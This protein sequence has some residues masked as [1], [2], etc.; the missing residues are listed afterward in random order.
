M[1][2]AELK[3][4]EG[5]QQVVLPNGTRVTPAPFMRIDGLDDEGIER[6]L[7]PG[8]KILAALRTG[9]LYKKEKLREPVLRSCVSFIVPAD[10]H[11]DIILELSLGRELG[12]IVAKELTG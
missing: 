6:V 9:N 2:G 11:A 3:T 8:A 5:T 10:Q 7:P 1:T 4:I 12:D